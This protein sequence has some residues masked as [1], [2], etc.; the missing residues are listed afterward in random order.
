M[1]RFIIKRLF[2]LIPT[3]LVIVVV[4][5]LVIR[6]APGSPF[7]SEKAIPLEVRAELEARYGFDKPLTTQLMNYV[8]NLLQGDFGLSTKYPQRTV[9]EIIADGLP[10][11][12]LLGCMALLWSLL[13]GITA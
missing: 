3:L 2:S 9:N 13:L 5:F 1:G 10:V 11:T 4:S 7:S 8:V 12:L 6:P